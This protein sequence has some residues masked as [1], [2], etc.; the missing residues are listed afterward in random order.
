MSRPDIRKK[1]EFRCPVHGFIEVSDWE[2]QVIQQP[3]F[4]RLRR[5]RQ[6]AW[7]EY[8]YPGATHTRF[9][10]SLGVMH[11]AT[12]LYEAVVQRSRDML[13]DRF[14][15][16]EGGL[17]RDKQ[18]V[19]FAAL[20][21]DTGHN[22]FSHG[23]EELM[24]LKADGETKYT[25]EEYS[26]W[27]IRHQLKDAIEKHPFNDNK[28]ISADEIASL[29]DGSATAERS[30]LWRELITGQIDADRMDYLLRD[31]LHAGVQ[32]GRYD[33]HRLLATVQAVEVGGDDDEQTHRLGISEGGL[34][35]AEALVL[36]RYFMFTQVY[37]HKTRV[38]CDIHLRHAM[39][40]LLPGGVFPTPENMDEYLK[41]DD[42]RVLGMLSEGRGG[43]HG[44]RLATRQIYKEVYHTSE[45]PGHDELAVVEKLKEGLGDL[46]AEEYSAGK[47]WYKAGLTDIPVVVESRDRHILPLS[48]LSIMVK[49]MKPSRQVLLFSKPENIAS[50]RAKREQVLQA[51]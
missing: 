4:Q 49:A 36:A 51:A 15:Y 9:E 16:D 25:H 3:A 20:L 22:P 19:R 32:Y 35:A 27:I 23:P 39:K 48:E 21:H 14:N 29:V 47:S 12:K 38:A 7:T 44:R 30:V 33:L 50:A 46:I 10:H 45:V 6:L 34:H 42:W 28:K 43:E 8:V 1:Y 17:D 13:I 40:E 26:A 31:S 11:V 24:P 41:W 37:F 5:I 2:R 18:L